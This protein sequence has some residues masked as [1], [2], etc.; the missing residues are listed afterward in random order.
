MKQ[1]I[2]FIFVCFLHSCGEDKI[3]ELAEISHSDIHE[4]TD[5]SAAYLFYDETSEKGFELNRK[6]LISTTNW[7]VNVDKRLSLKQVIPNIIF[8]QDKKNNASHKN[9]TAKNYYTCH[10]LEVNAL[11]F[12]DFTNTIYHLEKFTNTEGVQFQ[13]I[14]TSS[15]TIKIQ[16]SKSNAETIY[17]TLAD[18]ENNLTGLT[19]EALDPIKLILSFHDSISFQSYMSLKSILINSDDNILIARDEFIFN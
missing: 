19:K 18:F 10:D 8:L 12:I 13:I 5:V 16:S 9:E 7:L 6:N 1:I 14:Y 3:I 2:L 15:D 17:T 11:G 4:I